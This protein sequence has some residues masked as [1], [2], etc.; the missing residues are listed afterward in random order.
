M[1]SDWRRAPIDERLRAALGF[2]E[3]MTLRPAELTA[4][5]GRAL[6]AAGLSPAAIRDAVYVAFL[7][8]TYDRVADSFGFRL[9]P[10]EEYRGIASIL[11]K[12][13]YL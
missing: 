3:V 2:L 5:H 4:D 1:L 7:F 6:R 9:H 8:N 10:E 11:L 13:G 12:R